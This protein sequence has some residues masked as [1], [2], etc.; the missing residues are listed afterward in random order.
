MQEKGTFVIVIMKALQYFVV[1]LQC[2][3]HK[4]MTCSTKSYDSYTCS[5]NF[6]GKLRTT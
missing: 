5:Q 4:T 1:K 3:V 6:N 2:V